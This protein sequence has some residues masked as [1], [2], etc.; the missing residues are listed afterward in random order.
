VGELD[1]LLSSQNPSGEHLYPLWPFS[2]R[3]RFIRSLLQMPIFAAIGAIN[4]P[5]IVGRER[6]EG[7]ARPAIFVMRYDSL[8][9]A[10]FALEALPDKI[11]RRVGIS[12]T[13]KT[14]H[15]TRW[16][17]ATVALFFNSFRY[18]PSGSLHATLVHASGL[19]DHGWSVLFLVRG[20][21]ATNGRA[22]AIRR[23]IGLLAAEFGVPV[24]PIAITGLERH[25][26]LLRIPYR[27]SVTVSFGEP[28][29]YTVG[30]SNRD[31]DGALNATVAPAEVVR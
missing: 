15:T 10:P 28:I 11:R 25:V 6:L 21:A 30:E 29:R 8:L 5:R 16:M 31:V 17:G 14:D 3:I 24:V 9:D 18:S 23:G 26:P 1:G 7:L 20:D 19:L 22:G 13:W 12:T 4:R 2:H 27:D